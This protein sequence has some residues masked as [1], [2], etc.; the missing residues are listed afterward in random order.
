MPEIQTFTFTITGSISRQDYHADEAE[1]DV[2]AA[3]AEVLDDFEIE[4]V[5]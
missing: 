3:L 2:R 4:G 1:R 5:R